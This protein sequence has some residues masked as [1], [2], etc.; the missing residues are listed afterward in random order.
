LLPLGHL[1]SRK[2]SNANLD[3]FCVFSPVI[4]Y[5]YLKNLKV[6]LNLCSKFALLRDYNLNL[7]SL[8]IG[9]IQNITFPI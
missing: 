6:L 5:K 2:A 7:N 1:T 3:S 9:A 4:L 8:M